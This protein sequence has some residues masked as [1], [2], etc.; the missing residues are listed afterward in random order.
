MING[1]VLVV[2]Y[3][4]LQRTVRLL[5]LILRRDRSKEIESVVLRHQVA[6]PQ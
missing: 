1:R 5:L 4:V 2:A 3:T 6:V